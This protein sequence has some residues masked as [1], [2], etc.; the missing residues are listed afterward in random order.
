MP[1]FHP[2]VISR[3]VGRAPQIPGVHL[4]ILTSWADA[5]V[6]GVYDSETQNDSEFIQ[7]ILVDVLGY[8]GSSAGDKWNLA[9]NQPVG[10]GNVD[11]ALG[12]FTAIQSEI[13][14]PFE[15]K[16][17]KTRDLDAVMPGRHKSPVQQAWEYAM[18]AVGARWVL[19]S[20]YREIRLYAV[21]FGRKHY[22]HFDLKS[23]TDPFEYRR[24]QLLL[25]PEGLLAGETLALLM[26]SQSQ[27]KAITEQLYSDYSSLRAALV[28]AISTLGDTNNPVDSVHLAQK[29]LDRV[30]F[31]AFAEDKG[32]LPERTLQSV[33]EAKNPFRPEPAWINFLALFEAIDKGNA[34]LRIPGYNGGLFAHDDVISRLTISD[35]ICDSF[36]S[37]GDYDFDSEVSVNILGHIFEQSVADIEELKARANPAVAVSSNRSAKRKREGIYYT[38]SRIT[39]FM[40]EQTV[41]SW[42]TRKKSEL[43]FNSLPELSDGDYDSIR[44]IHRGKRKGQVV[45][46]DNIARHIRAWNA[47]REAL[48]RIRVLD[49]ACGS[50]AFLIE[51]FD[52]L[53]RE[54]QVVNN[55]LATLRGGQT[56]LIRWDKHIL[57]NNLFGVDINEESVEISKLSLWLKTAN[58]NETL[59]YLDDKIL[60]GNSLIEA[61]EVAGATA[62]NFRDA[63]PDVFADGGFDIVIGNPPYIDSEEMVR[64][65]Q[66]LARDYLSTAF[67]CTRGNWD[68]YIAFFERG[69]SLLR[70]DG[71][72]CYISPDKWLGRPF[73]TE[74]RRHLQSGIEFI[75]E[76]G[77]NVFEV[78]K[79]DAVLTKVVKAGKPDL[80]I[81][82]LEGDD[83]QEI[84]SVSKLTISPG[85]PL[86]D[87]FSPFFD[88][89]KKV[90]EANGTLQAIAECESAC[91][92]S[93]TYDLK[94]LILELA[95][96]M[97]MRPQY[98]KVA[99]TGTLG[100]FLFK[101]GER[102]MTYLREKYMF[103]VVSR[104]T[105]EHHLGASYVRRAAAKKIIIKGL[106]LLEGALDLDAEFVPGKSTLVITHEDDTVLKAVSALI[107]SK[108]V[109]LFVKEKNRSSSYNQGV[110]FNKAMLNSIPVPAEFDCGVFASLVDSLVRQLNILADQ[111]AAFF[112]FVATELGVSPARGRMLDWPNS[113]FGDFLKLLDSQGVRLTLRKKAEWQEH[114]ERKTAETLQVAHEVDL[115]DRAIDRRVYSLYFLTDGQ[116][117]IVEQY[118]RRGR[119]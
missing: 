47:Y 28:D 11:V 32:L 16:G 71:E 94:P 105:F 53:Y 64:S 42:L 56:E 36:R 87:L 3:R 43:G 61:P 108:L 8:A 107:N 31:I 38:P 76:V 115:M 80:A 106:T 113:D 95:S 63:F 25:G 84:R 81:L 37:L 4:S 65:G 92:T 83:V 96:P 17:A 97:H 72:L 101:W 33:Y 12:R 51:V 82:R 93:D 77:R 40:V 70:N 54:G 79:V 110:A 88:L 6:K 114:F 21:G 118:D 45:Y 10:S 55:Q 19:V 99:N 22:E 116:A 44:V 102:P 68:V 39:W 23:L 15:L 103:P 35:D 59:V 41:G 66:Q 90:E 67:Q 75:C 74:L 24:F 18:D 119:A 34:Q 26:E 9:K 78:A 48:S 62:F 13:C 91:A 100:R 57:A 5:L 58:R 112:A 104:E 30:L 69:L 46:N 50:G 20:N 98:Y 27:D 85:D 117:E 2:R 109:S 73:G 1:L 7:R 60:L 14:A 89:I 52:Y 29:V 49:P 86:D 111:R